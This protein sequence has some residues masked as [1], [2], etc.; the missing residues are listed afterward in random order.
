MLITA[1]LLSLAWK[2]VVVAGL[3]LGLLRLA[4]WRSAGERSMI[5]HAGLVALLALPAA[6]L[7]LPQWAPL[8]A[9]WSFEQAVPIA[10]TAT[11]GG[12]AIDP[13]PA[14]TS[15]PVAV[16]SAG[17]TPI[18]FSWSELAPFL[19]LAPLL[20]LSGVMALAVVRLFA[21][22]GRAEILVEGSWLSALAEAQRR[23]G[24][25]H[26]TA[27]LVSKELR[28]PISWGVLRPTIVLSPKA[29]AASDEAEAII[30][31]ELAHVARLDW[32]KLLGARIACAV[33]WFN[34]FVWMLARE[35]HQLREE[36]A[37]DAVLMADIDGPDYATLLV[38][39][40]RHDNQGTLLAAHGVAPGKDS[41]K[42]RITRVLDG[43]LKRGP[44]SASWMLMSLVVLAGITAPLAAFSA[45]A[46]PEATEAS[47]TSVASTTRAATITSSSSAAATKGAN[48]TAAVAKPLSAEELVSMRAVGVTP[49]YVAE[50]R[51]HKPAITA[52][53][54]IGAKA[55]GVDP[56]YIKTMRGIF[57]GTDIDELV[58]AAALHI[59]PRFARDMKSHFPDI[60]IDDVIALRAMGIDCDFVTDM[61][62]AGVKMRSA[63]DAIELRATSGFR[64]VAKPR[65]AAT[66]RPVAKAVQN[67]N[68]AIVDLE[69]GVIEARRAD[70][71]TARIEFPQAPEPP[72]PPVRD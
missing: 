20:L 25:K 54:I 46:K 10:Q 58:G 18:V 29:V 52:D 49:E 70:G 45:T 59:E 8:P 51:E 7:L 41:L 28:S 34:P 9:S 43:S 15:V 33:F 17:S 63:D 53:E 71:R 39:A 48:D 14:A 38:G 24:F 30:A 57:P 44:A 47:R 2:S 37:D 32:A 40:A 56:A 12:S 65:P 62:K 22:R 19:Y 68:V 23:M 69:R 66:P 13:A 4:R 27:L 11:T 31:H 1:I 60:S 36:A 55:A 72:K 64:P 61:Q 50:M 16:D 67:G 42:R 21:M 26:G 3:T 5:A 6:I 35:S